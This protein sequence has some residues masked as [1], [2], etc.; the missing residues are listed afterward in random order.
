M[1][2]IIQTRYKGFYCYLVVK[3]IASLIYF[4]YLG[5]LELT[6]DCSSSL[7]HNIV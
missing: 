5:A 6:Q 2:R 1:H 4:Y 3:I 7:R